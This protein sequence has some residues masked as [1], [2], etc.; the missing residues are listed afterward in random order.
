MTELPPVRNLVVGKNNYIDSWPLFKRIMLSGNLCLLT[1]LFCG[2]Y[3]T[4]DLIFGRLEF[5]YMYGIL[6]IGS[7]VSLFL[8]RN[9][10][11]LAGRLTYLFTNLFVIVLFS[12]A[13]SVGSGIFSYYLVLIVAA[14]TIFGYD[15]LSVGMSFT[16]VT[17]IFFIIVYFGEFSLLERLP[18]N[19]E[20]YKWTF[21]INFI[22]S[23]I[24][25]VL[26]IQYLISINHG[27]MTSIQKKEN[28]LMR[29]AS[30]LSDSRNRFKL[31]LQGSSAGI[32]DW[33]GV[34][35][36]LYISPLLNRILG[37]SL[38]Q[39][40]DLTLENFLEFTHPED[41]NRV[42]EHLESHLQNHTKFEVEFRLKNGEGEYI[43]VL[44]TGQ[45]EW[46]NNNTPVRMVGSIVDITERKNSEKQIQLQNEML[47][48]ANA[49]LDRFVYSVS[50]DLKS[51]LSSVLG[52]MSIADMSNDIGE[53]QGCLVMMRERINALNNFIEEVIDYS[54]NT[55]TEPEMKE[56]SVRA[57]VE[58]ILENLKYMDK[59]QDIRVQLDIDPDLTLL[60]DPG[61]VKIV[62][63]N[64]IGNAVKYHHTRQEDP[65]IKIEASLLDDQ[66]EISVSDNG[67]GIDGPLKDRI[68]D[69]FFRAHEGSQGSGLGL[70][71]AREM[72]LKLNGKI[73]VESEKN[74]GSVFRITLPVMETISSQSREN[75]W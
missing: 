50:H 5:L 2:V 33:D 51:P 34:N 67:Q 75:S 19:P 70:Y 54:R 65:W 8:L 43:W 12:M 3:L 20:Y 32:W 71:I 21:G 28:D 24:L 17:F 56:I 26:M 36:R 40:F 58:K 11:L 6:I 73:S 29:L 39:T 48:K 60:T 7:L 61:R 45:A 9:K 66:A 63:N 23:M 46:N 57:L 15:H 44:D 27:S 1:I 16:A 47:E 74:K 62:L 4:V 30:E 55:R 14:L 13:E 10:H 49:E 25:I 37:Y 38:E 42:K 64:L 22:I 18:V 68:F 53:V 72:I 35:N 41:K 59:M 69:M 31:A 52:L